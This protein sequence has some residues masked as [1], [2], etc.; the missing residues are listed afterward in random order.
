MARVTDLESMESEQV[1]ASRDLLHLVDVSDETSVD[2]KITVEKLLVKS[3][4]AG[5]AARGFVNTSAQNIAGVKTFEDGIVVDNIHTSGN[6]DLTMFTRFV[7]VNAVPEVANM[8]ERVLYLYNTVNDVYQGYYLIKDGNNRSRGQ[9]GG[10]SYT[11]GTGITVNDSTAVITNDLAASGGTIGGNTS[12]QGDLTVTGDIYQQG[13]SYETHAEKL[14]TKKDMIITRDGAQ[15][16]LASGEMSGIKAEHYNLDGDDGVL[17]FDSTGTAR[18]GDDGD[19]QPLAT[20][21][22]EADMIDGAVAKWNGTNKCFESANFNES[23][24]AGKQPKTMSS[25]VTV[26]GTVKTTVESAIS[27]LNTYA[28]KKQPSILSSPIVVDGVSKT[29]VEDTLQAINTMVEGLSLGL[30]TS[31]FGG[32]VA[33]TCRWLRFTS[34]DRKSLKIV[35]NTLIKVGAKTFFADTDKIYDLSG[36]ISQ[37]GKDYFV[38]LNVSEVDGEDVWS[39]SAT[40]TKTS[41]TSTSRYIGRFHTLCAA[42]PAGTTMIYPTEQLAS[43]AQ[44]C[45]APYSQDSDP[46]F[47]AFYLKA[48]TAA[49]TN[50]N[51][52]FYT[53]PFAHP[54]AG[55]AAGDILPESVWCLTFRPDTKYEDAMFYDP[56]TGRAED[57]YLQ[58]G[59]GLSTRSAYG[60]VTLTRSRT[61]WSHQ[62]DMLA[63]GKRLLKDWEFTAASMGSN[64]G[65]NI[66]GSAFPSSSPYSGGHN[67]TSSRRMVSMWGAEDMCGLLWQWL[68]EYVGNASADWHIEDGSS[69]APFGKQYWNVYQ[70]FAGGYWGVGAICGSR[71]RSANGVRSYVASNFGGRGSSRVIRTIG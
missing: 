45:L 16:P 22:E 67:D 36:D 4:D 59:T 8:E 69:N 13:T 46:D 20:R 23:D 39:L 29:T 21:A 12:V 28:D 33:P 6:L 63:V 70:L 71:C 18:V 32:I 19:T 1:N 57:I 38:Y 34:T 58:S 11:G 65:T 51:S 40:V 37:N 24:V 35:A 61:P 7:V 3:P 10:R 68:E 42:V 27:A 25:S 48:A 17:A 60:N 44:V 30:E 41:N 55:F 43:G 62:S 56:V 66:A 54:L 14:Y 64:Q 26:E 47:Y 2:K 53:T 52:A 31:Y 5:S 9:I 50:Q 15:S 49:S